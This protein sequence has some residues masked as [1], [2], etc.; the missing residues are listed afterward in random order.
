MGAAFESAVEAVIAGDLVTL[1][2]LLA[3]N[4]GLV[5]ARSPRHG[6][7]LL[8]YLS[9][10]GVEDHRQRSPGNAV[11]IAR[12]LL[13]AGAEVD[14]LADFYGGQCPTLTLLVSSTPPAK[15][16]VQI[17][18]TELLLDF[19]AAIEGTGEGPWKSPLMT[20]LAFGFLDTARVLVRRGAQVRTL[21]AAAGLGD[22][23]RA[24]ALLTG[25]DAEDRHRATALAAQL[26]H[27]EVLRL[28]LDNGEDPNRF[29]PP[30]CHA[31][32]TPLH[33][34]VAA[35]HL[36]VVRLLVARGA[37]LDVEDTIHHGTPLAWAEH[38]GRSEIAGYLR[39]LKANCL[40]PQ[41]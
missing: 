1:R 30:S 33:Q 3:A 14:A 9:A 6:A 39:G 17:P 13:E 25:A 35:G 20:A 31:H 28:L 10:N 5:F 18:L 2:D 7:T 34:A 26:G 37:R 11:E 4:P 15:A 36:D 38:C 16:G 29:N 40:P 12:L 41:S 8:H 21:A 27:L 24:A 23:H 22:L 19:G 32:S